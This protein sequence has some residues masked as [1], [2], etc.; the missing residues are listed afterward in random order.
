MFENAG[1]K[2]KDYIK[3][4]F[5]L[6]TI[7]KWVFICVAIMFI[8]NMSNA[9]V[10]IAHTNLSHMSNLTI[11]II[12]GVLLLGFVSTI[13]DYVICLFIYAMGDTVDNVKQLNETVSD[14]ESELVS[15]T[16]KTMTSSQPN[17]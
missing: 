7:V 11:S 13:S 16:F 1:K 14:M 10:H 9:Y 8:A 5:W 12:I 4:V 17:E 3:A 15:L 2:I 6:I